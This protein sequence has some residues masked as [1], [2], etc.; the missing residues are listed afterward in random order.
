MQPA[1][2]AIT[3]P[4]NVR[5]LGRDNKIRQR[6]VDQRGKADRSAAQPIDLH[7]AQGLHQL[8]PTN[9][10]VAQADAAIG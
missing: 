8:V 6:A 4:A 3:P 7:L 2:V 5:L 1:L 10:W 9:V